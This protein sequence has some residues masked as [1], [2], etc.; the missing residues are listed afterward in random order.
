MNVCAVFYTYIIFYFFSFQ[1]ILWRVNPH[2]WHYSSNSIQSAVL[3]VTISL[4][5]A[6][7]IVY[8]QHA[9]DSMHNNS[10]NNETDL[11]ECKQNPEKN[12]TKC[13]NINIVHHRGNKT[14]NIKENMTQEEL[15]ISNLT[16]PIQLFIPKYG[17]AVQNLTKSEAGSE[18]FFVKPSTEG[19]DFLTYHQINVTS[20]YVSTSVNVKPGS[21]VEFDLFIRY[22]E[23]PTSMEY[24]FKRR[25][26]DYSS[27]YHDL[28]L[29]KYV[30]CSMDPYTFSFS[31]KDSGH[32]GLHY[33]GIRYLHSFK[34]RTK[35]HTT[36]NATEHLL[37]RVRKSVKDPCIGV[38][39]RK[40]RS[41]AEYKNPP[42][43]KPAPTYKKVVLPDFENLT[44][45]SYTLDITSGTCMFWNVEDQQWSREGCKV[46]KNTL[47]NF[48][49]CYKNIESQ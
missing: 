39:K 2:T 36:I 15:S 37:I 44:D 19:K 3:D 49:P 25:I 22:N 29:K 38:G 12:I 4:S 28:H 20:P 10:V 45:I 11:T 23:K 32:T 6:A 16:V 5:K 47:I 8:A 21:D 35:S 31:A 26:P 42:P 17:D 48:T 7:N 43:P 1:I 13:N 14:D 30:N 9:N 18:V 40:K 33:L 41:C 27:C 46:R 24:N 34:N